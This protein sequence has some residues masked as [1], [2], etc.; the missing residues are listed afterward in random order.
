MAQTTRTRKLL[1]G[2]ALVATLLAVIWAYQQTP[3]SAEEAV[4]APV[5]HNTSTRS[6]SGD[7]MH[8]ALEK[9][10]RSDSSQ[11]DDIADAFKVTSWFVPVPMPKVQP[12]AAQPAPPAAP[13][14]PFTY[15][16]QML[17]DGKLTVFLTRQDMNYSVKAGETIDDMYHVDS[18]ESQRIVFTYK[19]LNMQ[20]S[21]AI[22]NIN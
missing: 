7:P 22:G 1:L 4:V 15:L 13:P 14:L 21:L 5:K 11:P 2:V 9:L 3:D 16:G 20:Q 19:P 18:I 17:E 8:L 12:V 6:A 10:Q